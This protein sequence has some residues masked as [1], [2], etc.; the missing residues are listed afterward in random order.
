VTRTAAYFTD[1]FRPL[2]YRVPLNNDGTLPDNPVVEE[3]QLVGDF[4][5]IPGPGVFNA[6]GIDAT[7][8]GNW[9]VIV[10]SAIGAVYRVDPNTGFASEIDLNG[11]SVPNGDGILLDGKTLYVVQNANNQLTEIKLS[12]H[13][14]S[15]NIVRV[16]TVQEAD[17]QVPTTVAEFGHWLYV[18]NARFGVP[19]PSEAEYNV[20]Q[21]RK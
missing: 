14:T 8:N 10:N 15:G 1:S 9:L 17:F 7:P 3:I 19:N 16:V 11:G 21:V 4:V 20:V 18:V 12:P 5:F 13:L 6:N 2:I